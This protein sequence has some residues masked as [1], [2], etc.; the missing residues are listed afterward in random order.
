MILVGPAEPIPPGATFDLALW[1]SSP[2]ITRG[3]QLGLAFDPSKIQITGVDEGD[4]YRSWAT[5]NQATTM[6]FPGFQVDPQHGWVHPVRL[7]IMGGAG[8]P[9]YAGG[10]AGSGILA[11]VHCVALPNASGSTGVMLESVVVVS[12][13]DKGIT[14]SAPTV[15]VTDAVVSIGK[16]P[17]ATV[18]LATPT[19]RLLAP[20]APVPWG[21]A[22]PGPTPTL[23]PG[24][25][26]TPRPTRTPVPPEPTP[27]R[28]VDLDPSFGSANESE[29]YV[30]FPDGHRE[31]W[32]DDKGPQDV[33]SHL[34]DGAVILGSAP[35]AALMGHHAP[36]IP[37]PT[38]TPT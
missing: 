16:V 2:T 31:M 4:Y 25:R 38:F 3:A 9:P 21:T 6:L 37:S 19:P 23:L 33:R 15:Q 1:F 26:A 11:T 24:L 10:P 29:Y 17:G 14:E 32:L 22:F 34:P 36:P 5:G 30:G 35:P 20:N 28:I 13:T 7:T 12:P 8:A 18:R 27:A